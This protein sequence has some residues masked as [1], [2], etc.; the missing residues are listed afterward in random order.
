MKPLRKNRIPKKKTKNQVKSKIAIFDGLFS[1]P[2]C[3][4]D[5]RG[6]GS[7]YVLALK[8]FE[9]QSSAREKE[10]QMKGSRLKVQTDIIYRS[11]HLAAET[12]R[13]RRPKSNQTWEELAGGS[14]NPTLSPSPQCSCFCCVYLVVINGKTQRAKRIVLATMRCI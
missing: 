7:Y 8:Q 10:N 13:R 11:N 5:G 2:S 3:Q 6:R 9:Q 4:D 14:G 1:C 12:T